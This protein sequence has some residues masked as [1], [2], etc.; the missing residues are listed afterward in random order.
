MRSRPEGSDPLL[1][2]CRHLRWRELHHRSEHAHRAALHGQAA[3]RLDSAGR[4]RLWVS[5]F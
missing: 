4:R 1:D 2:W 5:Q 3:E